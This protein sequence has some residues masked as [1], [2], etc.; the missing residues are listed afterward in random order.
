MAALVQGFSGRIQAEG[1]KIILDPRLY[2]HR[3]VSRDRRAQ[4][5]GDSA[6]DALRGRTRMIDA[7]GLAG[8]F[9]PD[10]FARQTSGQPPVIVTPPGCTTG[11]QP[12]PAT[13]AASGASRPGVATRKISN[14]SSIAQP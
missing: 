8:G 9:H 12:K 13:S 1:D 7:A 2:H 11:C 6:F 3:G 14:L 4:F 10:K 5:L